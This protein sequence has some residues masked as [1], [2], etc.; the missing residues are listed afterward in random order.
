M[1]RGSRAPRHMP[2]TFVRLAVQIKI[3]YFQYY[4]TLSLTPHFR[5]YCPY[6]PYLCTLCAWL[7][8]LWSLF[9]VAPTSLYVT[10]FFKGKMA[11]IVTSSLQCT[12][13]LIFVFVSCAFLSFCSSS[14]AAGRMVPIGEQNLGWFASASLCQ[15]I[16]SHYFPGK[17]KPMS[18]HPK[19]HHLG[20]LHDSDSQGHS[21]TIN[22]VESNY[23]LNCQVQFK[24]LA[25]DSLGQ[26]FCWGIQKGNSASTFP[27]RYVNAF[28]KGSS[29][30]RVNDC[31]EVQLPNVLTSCGFSSLYKESMYTNG[32][33]TSDIYLTPSLSDWQYLTSVIN[34]LQTM[35]W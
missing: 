32:L 28:H 25:W 3:T 22:F 19:L 12:L 11:N 24:L 23:R 5:N 13:L 9:F 29:S 6:S 30:E 34:G 10:S 1:G 26:F 20:R 21:N 31:Q 2:E 17:G 7:C 18:L 8:F 27:C 14:W 4:F 15:I 33:P 16:N 35:D